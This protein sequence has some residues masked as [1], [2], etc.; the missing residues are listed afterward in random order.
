M[1][2]GPAYTH[3]PGIRWA[4]FTGAAD[5]RQQLSQLYGELH[6]AIV[7]MVLAHQLWNPRT[8]ADLWYVAHAAA[9]NLAADNHS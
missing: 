5:G 7:G 9:D 6:I 2:L 4:R 1:S 3:R 8:V